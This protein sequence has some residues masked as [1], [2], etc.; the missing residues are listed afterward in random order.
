MHEQSASSVCPVGQVF[1]QAQ[2]QVEV[3]KVLPAG[4]VVKEHTQQFG[5]DVPSIQLP[6]S[7]HAGV[8]HVGGGGGGGVHEQ[9]ASSVCP[10]GQVF[11]QAQL[12]VEVFKVLPAGHVVKEHTQQFG[13]DVPSIQLPPSEHAGVGHVGGGGGGG[14]HEQSDSSV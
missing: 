1:V 14:V 13:G 10:V 2:L 6:P 8:G 5:G 4:H 3:F 9:S 7:E 11:V 12:Q